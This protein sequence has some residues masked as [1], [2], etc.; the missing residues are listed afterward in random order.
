[1]SSGHEEFPGADYPKINQDVLRSVTQT[2]WQFYVVLGILG[3]IVVGGA[4]LYYYQTVNGLGVWGVN[5]PNYWGLDIPT[6]IFWI[7]FS[8]SGTL[9][10]AIL[11]LTKSHW[12]N[13]VYRVAELMTGFAL[14]TASVVVLT[15]VGRP[16]RLWYTMPYPNLRMIWT[17]FR[18][19]L[20]ADVLGII[21]YLT[22][23]LTFLI[24]G[25][26]PDFAALR[27]QTTGWRK[28][29]Y[30][31]LSFGWKGTDKQWRHFRRTYTMI[32]VFIIPIAIGMHSVTSWVPSMTINP[33]AHSTIFP[34]LFVAGAL[35][36][37][38]GGVIMIIIL[39]RHFLK[40]Q[41]YIQMRHLDH[42]AKLLLLASMFISYIY[43]VEIFVPSY[44]AENFEFMPLLAK[45]NGKYSA[46]YYSMIFF[47]SVAP[48][49]L[50]FRSM[51]RN[52]LVLFAVSFAV[53]IGMYWERL[54]M[55]IPTQSIG[56]LPST[57]AAFTP[58][59]VEIGLFFWEIA[60]FAFLMLGS[61]KLIPAL[62]IF[63]VKELLPVPKRG[64][65][66]SEPI[67]ANII[68][69]ESSAAMSAA[70]SN[71][72]KM[73]EEPLMSTDR[74]LDILATKGRL[75]A[76]YIGIFSYVDDLLKSVKELKSAGF[77]D[78]EVQSP[79]PLDEI[80]EA[81]RPD[82]KGVSLGQRLKG[83]NI[84]VI[85]FSVAG[86]IL[87]AG[88]MALFAGWSAAVYPIQ[89]GG[90]PI[91]SLPP[92]IWAA[93]IIG[94]LVGIF[95]SVAGLFVLGKLPSYKMGIYSPKSSYDSFAVVIKDQDMEKLAIGRD[96][97]ENCGAESVDEVVK[98]S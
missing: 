95:G 30:T 46:M 72:A 44:K 40:F 42:L 81:T 96:I 7:G 34:L 21:A 53:Q 9:L 3:A 16:W 92:I 39:V 61:V 67:P 41:A 11:L 1:M 58:S 93:A 60:I 19:P 80:D 73:T 28:R 43:L 27:D 54:L 38:V 51:R 97:L 56:P 77:K 98:S 37:G 62:S 45:L 78:I 57:W 36:S 10:S 86:A 55:V 84:Q 75:E 26:I 5:E 13:P 14:M 49:V 12:R 6:F 71:G 20:M 65:R 24:I 18:S 74:S 79:V 29:L 83:R 22:A 69:P 23:S 90:M 4:G 88:G 63:E 35:L 59:W 70:A 68:G 33:G 31:V 17:N 15:H 82:L 87:G 66:G 50:F 76:A 89:T 32:A 48:L 52:I 64:A 47:N 94:A 91:I 25:S 2:S 8:L 85:R